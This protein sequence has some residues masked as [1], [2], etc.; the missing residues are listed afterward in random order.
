MYNNFV[1]PL[2]DDELDHQKN[3]CKHNCLTDSD[4]CKFTW[5]PI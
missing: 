1:L 3:L 5:Y 2:F 4:L